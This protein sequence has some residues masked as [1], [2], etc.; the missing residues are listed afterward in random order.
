MV[1]KTRVKPIMSL[2]HVVGL[3]TLPVTDATADVFFVL[4]HTADEHAELC[5]GKRISALADFGITV[6]VEL[7]DIMC[8]F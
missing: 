8:S 4:G 6:F 1:R 3:L 7:T 2:P 5:R